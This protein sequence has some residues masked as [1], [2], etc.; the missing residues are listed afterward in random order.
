MPFEFCENYIHGFGVTHILLVPLIIVEH[1]QYLRQQQSR[2][3]HTEVHQHT[4]WLGHN[5]QITKY[6]RKRV[7][8]TCLEECFDEAATVCESLCNHMWGSVRTS[9]QTNPIVDMGI[10]EL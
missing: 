4:Q 7:H 8:L 5:P 10:V 3:Q 9:L 1:H 2:D 6:G